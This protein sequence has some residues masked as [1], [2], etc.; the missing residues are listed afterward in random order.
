MPA[1]GPQ[2]LTPHE[3]DVAGFV[4]RGRTYAEIAERLT[5]PPATVAEH[6]AHILQKL[7]FTRRVQIATWA[8]QQEFWIADAN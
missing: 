6:A 8:V 1:L 4:A 2:P 7:G 3:Q 5:L